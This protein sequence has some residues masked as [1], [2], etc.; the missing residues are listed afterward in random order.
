MSSKY[1]RIVVTVWDGPNAT[2][3]EGLILRAELPN[4]TMS[5]MVKREVVPA[6]ATALEVSRLDYKRRERLT[7]PTGG[8]TE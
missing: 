4:L 7:E 5:E 3:A 8:G 1:I 2:W 6:F